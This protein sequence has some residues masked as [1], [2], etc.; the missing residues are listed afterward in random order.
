MRREQREKKER[1]RSATALQYLRAHT[2]IANAASCSATLQRRQ[3][4]RFGILVDLY[5][6]SKNLTAP[7]PET[8]LLPPL[9]SATLELNAAILEDC[10]PDEDVVDVVDVEAAA[11][12]NVEGLG[13]IET[14]SINDVK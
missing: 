3:N 8:S 11:K 7:Q 12:D 14:T 6:K 9:P 10:S 2:R 1:R 13:S 5:A 4:E